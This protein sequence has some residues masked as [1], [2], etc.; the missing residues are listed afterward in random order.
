MSSASTH[1]SQVAI[2]LAQMTAERVTNL[3]DLMDS[4]YDSKEIYEISKR[5]NHVPIID[6]NK[7]K[8]NKKEFD[9]A[10]KVRYNQRSSAERIMSNLKDNY[11]GN[12]I[13]VKGYKKVMAHL[14]FGIIVMTADQLLRMVM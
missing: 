8:G 5:L 9:P 1:D 7:R 6:S 13:R 14:M 10:K 11:G 3:Y 4:A 2:P 12:T